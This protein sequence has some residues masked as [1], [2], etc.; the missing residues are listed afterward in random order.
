ML[1]SRSAR[2]CPSRSSVSGVSTGA[3]RGGGY[4]PAVIDAVLFDHYETLITESGITPTRAGRLAD[5]LGLP[6]DA[7]RRE[8][9]V[10]RPLVVRGELS[11]AAA[12]TE[13]SQLTIGCADTAAIQALCQ[14]RAREKAVVFAT[15]DPRIAALISSLIQSG[16]KLGVVSNGFDEDVAGWSGCSLASAFRY[17]AFSCHERTAKP[18]AEI[19]RRALNGLSAD[20]ETTL[21]VGD[22]GDE[23]LEGAARVGLRVARATWFTQRRPSTSSWRDLRAPSEVL[24]ILT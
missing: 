13:I 23:E 24:Y 11:F 15:I 20:P 17:T 2:D 14:Q 22:G 3:A 10:R 12:L 1:C 18:E 21:Y 4:D 9:K 8:W 5:A 6:Q 7:Y 19:Y 16:V